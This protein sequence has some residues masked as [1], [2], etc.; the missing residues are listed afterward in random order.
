MDA[1][2]KVTIYR[3]VFTVSEKGVV[4]V[5]DAAGQVQGAATE[6]ADLAVPADGLT[7]TGISQQN[8]PRAVTVSPTPS[9]R[10]AS[11]LAKTEFQLTS[12]PSW[13]WFVV[14][15]GAVIISVAVVSWW[16]R[17]PSDIPP[18]DSV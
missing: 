16:S 12:L 6:S 18:L 9:Q 2:G 14:V 1:N 4:E 5:R 15:S 11:S 10:E 8:Q 3:K 7:A 13:V 17:R